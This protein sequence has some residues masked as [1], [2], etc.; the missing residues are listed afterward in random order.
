MF[1]ASGLRVRFL[2]VRFGSFMFSEFGCGNA[3]GVDRVIY[4]GVGEE[5]LQHSRVGSLYYESWFIRD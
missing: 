1:T 2:K 4:A 3:H 5:W